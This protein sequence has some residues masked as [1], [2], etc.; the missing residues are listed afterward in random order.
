MPNLSNQL[1]TEELVIIVIKQKDQVNL[2]FDFI[3]QNA[4]DCTFL[5]TADETQAIIKTII[6]M[7]EVLELI[8]THVEEC[9]VKL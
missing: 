2:G 9:H 7:Q 1:Y 6:A 3:Q 8:K 4:A 5:V